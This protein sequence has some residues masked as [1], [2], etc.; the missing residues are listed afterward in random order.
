MAQI[1]GTGKAVTHDTMKRRQNGFLVYILSLSRGMNAGMLNA[2]LSVTM[3]LMSLSRSSEPFL[4]LVSL[5]SA[6]YKNIA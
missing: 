4:T 5:S 1:Q 2:A 3:S 6:N